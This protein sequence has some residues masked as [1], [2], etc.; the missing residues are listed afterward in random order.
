MTQK[1]LP[2]VACLFVVPALSQEVAK[3]LWMDQMTTAVPALFCQEPQY[4]RQCFEVS[5]EE[6]EELVISSTRV[7]L[8]RYDQQIPETLVQPNDGA[9]WGNLVGSCV[10]RTYEIGFAERKVSDPRCN[11]PS[12]WTQ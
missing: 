6:C 9:R 1:L 10:G 11:D 8:Q 3:S 5:A 7:C 2:L 4:F 12:Q